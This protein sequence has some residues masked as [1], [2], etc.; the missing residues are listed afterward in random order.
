MDSSKSTNIWPQNVA[1]LD[2]R[3]LISNWKVH[4]PR[5][6]HLR[7]PGHRAF[8]KLGNIL[9]DLDLTP[10]SL[11]HV[12][13]LEFLSASPWADHYKMYNLSAKVSPRFG[14]F[15]HLL[16]QQ[17]SSRVL[18]D[19]CI[20]DTLALCVPFLVREHC[21][22]LRYFSGTRPCRESLS[23]CK[24]QLLCTNIFQLSLC[25]ERL[26]DSLRYR[27]TNIMPFRTTHGECHWT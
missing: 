7:L 10:D 18:E 5:S 12:D 23:F 13:S 11:L 6:H 27:L 20:L 17:R 21:A 19:A 2:D 26:C 14:S 3:R 24:Q 22:R 15:Y 25:C 1:V 8:P 16:P 9:I 4:G